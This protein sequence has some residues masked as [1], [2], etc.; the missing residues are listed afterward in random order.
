[1]S[2]SSSFDRLLADLE[3]KLG[4]NPA[5]DFLR[6]VRALGRFLVE[7]AT[8]QEAAMIVAALAYFINPVDLWPDP[9]YADDAAVILAVVARLGWKL[10]KYLERA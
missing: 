10:N 1:M 9:I 4:K 7:E 6:Q 5:V 3:R 8:P 2:S